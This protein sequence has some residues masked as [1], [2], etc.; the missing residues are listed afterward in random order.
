MKRPLGRPGRVIL[1][2]ILDKY[3]GKVWT[4]CIWLRIG[5][6]DCLL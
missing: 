1:E 3:D 4:A 6:I 5:N 2:W